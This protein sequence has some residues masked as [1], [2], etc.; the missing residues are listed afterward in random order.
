M[1]DYEMRFIEETAQRQGAQS[2]RLLTH[3]KNQP[4]KHLLLRHGYRF[5]GNVE[6]T[7]EPGLSGTRQ[8]F[9]KVL[10]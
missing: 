9:E 2:I 7:P 10:K 8:A 3:K 6:L 1:A 5:A 4:M